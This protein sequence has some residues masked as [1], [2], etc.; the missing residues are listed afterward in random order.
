[1]DERIDILDSSGEQ[2]G[3]AAWKSEAHRLGLWHR[4][5]HCWIVSPQLPSG[6][7]YLFAQRRAAVKE[8]WPNRL[9]VTV[10]GHL[11]AGEG[12]LEGGLREIEEELGLSVNPDEL[13]PLGTRMVESHIPAGLDRELHDVFLLVR[14]LSPGDLHLQE[15][16]VAAIVR[17]Q[18]QDVEALRE[19]EDIP[20]EKWRAGETSPTLVSLCEFVPGGDDYLP[21]MARAARDVLS[22][23]RPGN[24]F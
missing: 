16:E 20:A 10:A 3:R 5:F 21:R 8:T 24:L 7:P 19:G 2:T 11:G 4:C 18:L 6:G 13:I 9:D 12:T 17:L 15:K 14:P 1:M 22:G 23:G